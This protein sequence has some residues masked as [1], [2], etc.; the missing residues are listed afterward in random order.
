VQT[1]RPNTTE[2]I[3]VQRS[4]PRIGTIIVRFVGLL[5]VVVVLLAW[6]WS[7]R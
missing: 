1:I 5:V 2:P 3:P 4:A 7:R 6:G